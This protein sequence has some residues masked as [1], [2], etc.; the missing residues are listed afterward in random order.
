MLLVSNKIQIVK[1]DTNI[2]ANTQISTDLFYGRS[3]LGTL[4]I[5]KAVALIDNCIIF[6]GQDE[7]F[8]CF[9]MSDGRKISPL[10]VDM[11]ELIDVQRNASGSYKL[12]NAEIESMMKKEYSRYER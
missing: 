12:P 8:R 9:D 11:N 6:Y 5:S 1:N 3:I 2:K 10:E 4:Q 7:Y